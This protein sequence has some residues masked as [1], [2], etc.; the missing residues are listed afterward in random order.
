MICALRWA[1]MR[2]ILMFHNCQGQ[3]HKTVS[4][5]HNTSEEKGEPKRIR[6]EVLLLTSLTPYHQAKPAHSSKGPQLTNGGEAGGGREDA[7]TNRRGR[8][9]KCT[10]LLIDI[11][12]TSII[13]CP[14]QLDLR[15]GRQSGGPGAA[16]C[17]FLQLIERDHT[18]RRRTAYCSNAS[19]GQAKLPVIGCGGNKAL[20][21]LKIIK[22]VPTV[23]DERKN[24]LI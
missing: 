6:T 14:R 11:F 10:P 21:P 3:S 16:P 8:N 7:A 24:T 4:T 13:Y 5:D 2:T 22:Y 15:Q 18:K 17:F 12:S 20:R 19:E 23:S 9:T 1:A